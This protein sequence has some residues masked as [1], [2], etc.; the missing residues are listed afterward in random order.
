MNIIKSFF[1]TILIV[2]FFISCTDEDTFNT[3]VSDFEELD[4][5][6]QTYW[7]GSDGSGYFTYGNKIFYNSYYPDWNSWSGFVYS[8][9]I[10]YLYYNE[11]AKYAAFPSGGADESENYVVAHQFEKIVIDFEEGEEPRLVQLTNCTYT[12]LAIKYGYDYSKKFGGRDGSDPDW[13]KLTITGIGLSNEI[14][15]TVDFFL[16]DFRFE[17]NNEDYIVNK[18]NFVDLTNLGYVKRLEFELSSSDAGTPLYFCMDNLKGRIH[19]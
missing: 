17:D 5:E 19:Y 16:A 3:D 8:N 10:N 18:W 6:E 12:A 14:T 9:V 1:Y 15:G 4:L 13:F 7:N 11:I 2:A